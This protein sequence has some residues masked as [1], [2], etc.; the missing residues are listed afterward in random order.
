MT[1]DINSDINNQ[2]G[3][4]EIDSQKENEKDHC[5]SAEESMPSQD[6]PTDLENFRESEL[7]EYNYQ[8]ILKVVDNL[9]KKFYDQGSL[10]QDVEKLDSY[11]SIAALINSRI[12]KGDFEELSNLD[13]KTKMQLRV[14]TLR[15]NFLMLLK[16]NSMM[17]SYKKSIDTTFENEKKEIDD[18]QKTIEK[19]INDKQEH[20]S[21]KFNQEKENLTENLLTFLEKEKEQISGIEHKTLTHVLSIM[22]IF[23]AIITIIL[24]LITTTASWIN[25]STQSDMFLAFIVPNGVALVAVFALMILVYYFVNYHNNNEGKNDEADNNKGKTNEKLDDK[26]EELKQEK[27]RKPVYIMLSV[28]VIISA[29]LLLGYIA[30]QNIKSPAHIRYIISSEQY[31]VIED[32]EKSP[33]KCPH[34]IECNCNNIMDIKEY[35]E[36]TFEDKLYRFEYDESYIHNGNLY[37][38]AEHEV[39]E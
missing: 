9:E 1:S 38:C 12:E 33:H 37:F 11:F 2:N 19:E 8:K 17:V 3:K 21:E 10:V 27:K 23:S 14:N 7:Q 36:F 30:T 32:T 13:D 5:E 18:K 29:L 34:N 24:S 39:L 20:F 22:G 25:N 4:D 15:N 16:I 6:E 26:K 35:F 31:E 28:V